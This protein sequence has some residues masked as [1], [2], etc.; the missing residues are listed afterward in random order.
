MFANIGYSPLVD[1]APLLLWLREHRAFVSRAY[2]VNQA[3]S[4][5]KM[6]RAGANAIATDKIRGSS[7]ASVGDQVFVSTLDT[8][9]GL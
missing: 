4:W 5:K 7:F 3:E 9:A 1:Q 6:R 2:N 8:I